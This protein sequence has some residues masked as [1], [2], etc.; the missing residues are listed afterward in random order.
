M[1]VVRSPLGTTLAFA[2]VYR[3]E[4]TVLKDTRIRKVKPR[5][6]DFKLLRLT[7]PLALVQERMRDGLRRGC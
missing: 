5:G 1:S 7:L 3:Q 4:D 2:S 6:R